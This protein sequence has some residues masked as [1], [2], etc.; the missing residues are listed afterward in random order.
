MP[1][2]FRIW[3][4]V[5]TTLLCGVG[6]VA[7]AIGVLEAVFVRGETGHTGLFLAC[8]GALCFGCSVLIFLVQQVLMIPA[9]RNTQ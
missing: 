8:A 4:M 6:G 1:I 2:Y 7:V 9:T 5:T 3:S